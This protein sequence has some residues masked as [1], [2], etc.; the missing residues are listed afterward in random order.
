MAEGE[1]D[2]EFSEF[3]EQ[4]CCQQEKHFNN[5]AGPAVYAPS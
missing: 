1:L 5:G 3:M 4:F 2:I